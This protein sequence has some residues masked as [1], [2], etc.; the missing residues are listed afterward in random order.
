M[1]TGLQGLTLY[2]QLAGVD[3][4][5]KLFCFAAVDANGNIILG[6]DNGVVIGTLIEVDL[7][8]RPASA[9]LDG[10]GKVILSTT[11]AALT[12]VG[13]DG[14]GQ[15]KA[16]ATYLAGITLEGGNGGDIVPIKLF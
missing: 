1:A 2:S 7:S 5:G 16:A 12:L 9:Q 3:L 6:A 13:S 10:I 8:G 14:N 11:I 4:T 15:A